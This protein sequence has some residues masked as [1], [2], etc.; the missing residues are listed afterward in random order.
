MTI[1]IY[2]ARISPMSKKL[3]KQINISIT[4]GTIVK[5]IVIFLLLYVFIQIRELLLVILTS[6]ILASAVEPMTRWFMKRGLPR[7]LSVITIYLGLL[8]I[9]S[10]LVTVFVPPLV[11]DIKDVV[12]TIPQ[13][14]ESLTSEDLG[15]I[16]GYSFVAEQFGGSLDTGELFG[17]ISSFTGKA[18]LGVF[19]TA[20][21]FF[22]GIMSFILIVVI[23]FYLAVQEDGVTNFLR[24][25][26]P[27]KHEPYI[28]D[29]W[30]RSQRKIGLWMQGQL[31]LSVIITILTFL[32]LSILGVD[33]AFLLAI[34]AGVFE[35][36]PV[37][38]L[39]LSLIPAVGVALIQGG[40][41]LGLL[42]LGLYLIVQ[43]FENQLIHPLVVKKIVGIP[44][45]VAILA[46]II[47]AQIAGFLGILISVPVAA[48]LMEYLTDVEKRKIKELKDLKKA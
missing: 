28:L 1:Y 5:A 46:I 48:I 15:I 21:A 35:L 7:A 26:T 2:S 23:S 40:F 18:T 31:L 25:V 16:P 42:V 14:V 34:L 33:N 44:A 47:G 43:Q 19:A 38:G 41:A 4:A 24:I 12:S 9:L 32:G 22:G 45:L 17:Q 27:A 3:D 29:L 8:I 6:V 36:I 30:K 13:Y 10:V 20:S 11:S 37:F 39:L